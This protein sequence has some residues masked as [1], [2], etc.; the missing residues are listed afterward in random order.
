MCSAT[1]PVINVEDKFAV[2]LIIRPN[3][4]TLSLSSVLTST[5]TTAWNQSPEARLSLTP[6]PYTSPQLQLLPSIKLQIS[7]EELPHFQPTMSLSDILYGQVCYFHVCLVPVL[8]R[9]RLEI[10]WNTAWFDLKKRTHM[11]TSHHVVAVLCGG[12]AT[13][14]TLCNTGP[15]MW[16][17][18]VQFECQTSS[19]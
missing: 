4:W 11:W 14:V 16:S 9:A 17:G 1:Q 6:I 3:S 12:F 2:R 8:K 5:L 19:G 15:I 13:D 10:S 18:H 7:Q